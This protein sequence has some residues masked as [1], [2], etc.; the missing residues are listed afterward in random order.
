VA[1]S[2]RERRGRAYGGAARVATADG[3]FQCL[4]RPVC[5]RCGA[6]TRRT[7]LPSVAY[8]GLPTVHKKPCYSYPPSKTPRDTARMRDARQRT[9]HLDSDLLLPPL[10]NCDNTA[11]PKQTRRRAALAESARAPSRLAA[12]A[13][14]WPR[15]SARLFVRG[16]CP[17][18]KLVRGGWLRRALKRRPWRRNLNTHNWG[19]PPPY[20]TAVLF[21]VNSALSHAARLVVHAPRP[22]GPVPR[23]FRGSP[24]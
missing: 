24:L 3:T 20:R 12:G 19:T 13:A 18:F 14:Q 15:A 17:S 11:S 4:D 16:A 5:V 23:S 2:I 10:R 8:S 1:S 21:C 22:R 7:I 9:M 6:E